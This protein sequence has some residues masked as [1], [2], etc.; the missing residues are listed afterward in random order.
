M[1][2]NVDKKPG[3]ENLMTGKLTDSDGTIEKL[4]KNR[5]NWKKI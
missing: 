1:E 4:I 3:D 2:I 5:K